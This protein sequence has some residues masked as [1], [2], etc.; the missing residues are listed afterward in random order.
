VA[1]PHA[2]VALVVVLRGFLRI[3]IVTTLANVGRLDD[4]VSYIVV[5]RRWLKLNSYATKEN[6]IY[7]YL[8]I[9]LKKKKKVKNNIWVPSHVCP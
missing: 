3:D 5:G 6:N 9:E 7:G 8:V 4:G 2:G 1:F